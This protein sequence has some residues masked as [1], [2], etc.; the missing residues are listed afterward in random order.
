MYLEGCYKRS[1]VFL[2]LGGDR[3]FYVLLAD[4]LFR[5]LLLPDRRFMYGD[6]RSCSSINKENERKAIG[7]KICSKMNSV[8][9]G[10]LT[11][12]HFI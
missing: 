6:R 2:S 7:R 8:W 4:R 11:R 3:R 9:G 12:D 5:G 1:P 10:S